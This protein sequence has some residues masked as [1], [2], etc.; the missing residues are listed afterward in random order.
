[1]IAKQGRWVNF[2]IFSDVV[3][4]VYWGGNGVLR[5]NSKN[6]Q[7]LFIFNSFSVHIVK[8]CDGESKWGFFNGAF[9]RGPLNP[10]KLPCQS[11]K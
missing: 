8:I 5:K 1:M 11:R 10:R 9:F 2:H 4:C 3:D 7:K 6:R